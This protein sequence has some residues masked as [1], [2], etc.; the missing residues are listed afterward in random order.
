MWSRRAKKTAASKTSPRPRLE[1]EILK[2]RTNG[3]RVAFVFSERFGSGRR[4][5]FRLRTRRG[6]VAPFDRVTVFGG[7]LFDFLGILGNFNQGRFSIRP[8]PRPFP[9]HIRPEPFFSGS[10][11]QQRLQHFEIPLRPSRRSRFGLVLPVFSLILDASS[12]IRPPRLPRF[13]DLRVPYRVYPPLRT[14]ASDFASS[15]P[16]APAFDSPI[17]PLARDRLADYPCLS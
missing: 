3:T 11:D 10:I 5:R 7:E 4:D 12:A 9:R 14:S 15:L 6:L 1:N 17:V 8:A 13:R 2:R 16:P